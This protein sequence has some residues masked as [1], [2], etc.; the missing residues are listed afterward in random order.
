MLLIVSFGFH[1]N[2][3]SICS[4]LILF[5]VTSLFFLI[6]SIRSVKFISLFNELIFFAMLYLYIECFSTLL[7]F[8]A[9]IFSSIFFEISFLFLKTMHNSSLECHFFGSMWLNV[10]MKSHIGYTVHE[11]RDNICLSLYFQCLIST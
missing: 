6:N 3:Y 9:L 2:V 1:F 4:V 10:H 7:L 8:S 5:F 11:G